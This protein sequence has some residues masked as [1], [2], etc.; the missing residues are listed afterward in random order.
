[1]LSKKKKDFKRVVIICENI[2]GVYIL[3][4]RDHPKSWW[5]WH[6]YVE[7]EWGGNVRL[8]AEHTTL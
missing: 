7:E 2:I 5:M 3:I 6:L 1:M 8:K 4:L